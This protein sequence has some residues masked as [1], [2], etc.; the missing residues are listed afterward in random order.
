MPLIPYTITICATAR[1]VR[2]ILVQHQQYQLENGA[3]Q[4]QS[5]QVYTLQQWLDELISHASLLGFLP[6]DALPALILTSVA[7]TYLWEQAIETCL[8]KHEAA[9]LF[10][11][12]AMAK[13]AVE[14]NNLMLNWQLA[15]TEVNHDFITQETRQFFRWRHTFEALC[16]K[17]NAIEPARL[18]SLQIALFAQ[19]Q[20]LISTE[21]TLPTKIEL[22]GFD[23]ITPLEAH[24]FTLL[25]A[26]GV[27]V[28][29]IAMNAFNHVAIDHYAAVD[30]N[31]E[32]RAAV[33]WAK[34]KLAQN[35]KAQLAII[36]PA[37]GSIRR[38]LVDLLDDTFHPET[39][40]SSDYETPRCYDF[41]LG[42][43]LTE[44]AVVHSALQLLRVASNKAD[45][46]FD[47]VTP[48]LQDV[49]WS[50]TSEL[51][52]RAQLDAYM[53]RNMSASYSLDALTKQAAKLQS[54]G[55]VLDE[56][57]ENLTQILR[58]QNQAGVAGKQRQT[59]S[60]WVAAFVQL[61]DEL[62]WA[63]THSLSSHE[64]QTQQAFLKCLKELSGLDA[65]FGHVTA[66]V[67][68]QKI[69]ELCNATMFQAEAK[70]DIRIQILG[71]LETPAA[72]LD[73]VWALNM[74]DQHWPPAV[75]LNPLLPA[76]LQ[77]RCGTPNASAAVQSQFA[78][79][80]QARLMTCAPE[81]VFSYA[82]KE[83]EREL[84]PSPLLQGDA[85]Y[86]QANSIATL[87]ESLA[88]PAAMQML[89]DC[90]APAVL[91]DENV[92]GGVS[93][94]A[95]QAKC[96]AWAF[97]QYRLGAAKLET[98]VD[99]LDT[100]A[101]GSLLHKVLQLF[102]LDCV[103]LSN[104][105]ALSETELTEKIDAAIEKSIEDLS[106]QIS[107]HIPPQVLQIE[108][109]RLRQ[110]LQVWLTLELERADFVVDACEKKFELDVEGLKL[111]LS[112]DRIDKLKE[113]GLVVIDYKTSS[114]VTNASWAE[115]RITEPQL[116]IY[117][118]LALKYEQVL[119][120]SFAKIRSDE[121]K[122]V[123]LS[124]EEGVLPKVTAL[125][126]VTKSSAF[127]E[128][129]D[130]DALLEHWYIS[131]SNIAQE[132]KEGVASVT[133]SNEADLVYCDV[134]PLLRLPERQLQFEHML[135]VLKNGDSA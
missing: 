128:F 130:W 102:W 125:A 38:E 115:D 121:T 44:Y 73:A 124:A 118:V 108:R 42:L 104:L 48:L 14:A 1:L 117:V 8:A 24:L 134:K 35:P 110:L 86:K 26:C 5:A 101:R 87:A 45:F 32:C 54:N 70:G 64:F 122:F 36:S 2:G 103:S 111:N 28:E 49:Y 52:A 61:L 126:K 78:S 94:F 34:Q 114:V 68:V 75:K 97:Y 19:Y 71:L 9:A 96:P 119:A 129:S 81:V 31:S 80:V 40:H 135:A 127:Y 83:D 23:R 7:E 95:A 133:V 109:S 100:M 6:S 84:R 105:K 39:L 30:V 3:T 90:I 41:S 29:M 116:P 25:R 106:A 91:S 51:D 13:S 60:A 57:L 62:H 67:A 37:L 63:K 33:A 88:Q 16:A 99:G 74:N 59:L 93:L 112:I 65:I 66:S 85:I 55:I 132:I 89:E 18:I 82:I 27:Q 69:T 15:E 22:A 113:G 46:I 123:G 21:L 98:P 10:D 43:A 56:L 79:L 12:R 17:Q 58:F 92:R 131:L 120:V 20:K 47:E 11:I 77:R 50:K 4:W 72:Q 53:R 76:D 107:Y